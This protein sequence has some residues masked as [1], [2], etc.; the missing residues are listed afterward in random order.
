MWNHLP[1]G[2]IGEKGVSKLINSLLDGFKMLKGIL[3]LNVIYAVLV[4]DN[5]ILPSCTPWK[6]PVKSSAQMSLT[7]ATILMKCVLLQD[8]FEFLHLF[9]VSHQNIL[10]S[11]YISLT[12]S[13]LSNR[14]FCKCLGLW[15]KGITCSRFLH[16]VFTPAQ[17][18]SIQ[19]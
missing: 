9:K 16:T 5:K 17:L 7:S 6:Y 12:D 19:P 15:G 8:D 10:R 11:H 14:L 13:I 2:E 4:P 18:V 1:I 3:Y